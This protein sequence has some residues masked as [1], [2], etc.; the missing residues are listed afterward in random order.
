MEEAL[1]TAQSPQNSNDERRNA[2]AMDRARDLVRG[3]ESVD[4]RLR[5]QQQSDRQQQEGARAGQQS[6]Q[7]QGQEGRE[8]QS[9][10][11]QGRE[12][13]Q[14]GGGQP[15]S[16][17]TR[18]GG[19]GGNAG[20]TGGE[21]GPPMGAEARGQLSREMRERLNDARAL[22][23]ELAQRGDLDLD[24]L[25]QAIR[26][27]EGI[28][29]GIGAGVDPRSE[30]ELRAQVIDG[31]R[32]FEFQLGRAFGEAGGERV[33]IDRA[34]EVPPEYRKYVEEYYRALGRARPR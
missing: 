4:E 10:Q 9:Q 13:Q 11:G 31:L 17:E 30:R 15:G 20:L 28:A 26:Q 12:G 29:R 22:R 6:Q 25:D 21:G 34:G 5:Q 14:G 23:R 27:M 1:R 19:G 32:N 8:G 2:S 18:G 33:L 7:G 16:G 24:Q 3:M